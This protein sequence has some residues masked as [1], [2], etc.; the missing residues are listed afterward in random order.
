MDIAFAC[1]KCGETIVAKRRH[2]GLVT[3]CPHC[4]ERMQV[5]EESTID[6]GMTNTPPA[7][8]TMRGTPV[9][10]EQRVV[11]QGIDIP[12]WSLVG[13]MVKSAFAAIPATIIFLIL[14][15][16]IVGILSLI[17]LGGCTALLDMV[18]AQ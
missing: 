18:G 13:F 9:Q 4:N 5:P 10:T 7:P 1:S 11:L 15:W 16:S 3:R 17:F 2:A 12:F 14:F 6:E 8:Q